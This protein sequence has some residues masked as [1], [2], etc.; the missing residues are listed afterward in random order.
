MVS[1]CNT[2]H[3]RIGHFGIKTIRKTLYWK[4][5]KKYDN[6]YINNCMICKETKPNLSEIHHQELYIKSKQPL[7]LISI[8]IFCELPV[9]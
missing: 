2:Y 9:S 1:E 4:N 5:M 8:D 6:D 3:G 7:E